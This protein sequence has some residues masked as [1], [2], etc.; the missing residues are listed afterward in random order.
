DDPFLR[1]PDKDQ[2]PVVQPKLLWQQGHEGKKMHVDTP[3]AVVGDKVLVGSAFLDMEKEGDRALYCLDTGSGK[4]LWRTPLKL[5]PWG[6]PTVIGNTVVITGSDISYDLKA[7]DNTNK[8]FVGA[9][10]LANGK[11]LWRKDI[12]KGAITACAAAADGVVVVTGTDGNIRA[13]EIA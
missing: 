5:N 7:I 1:E 8:G 3:V 13:F 12:D 2:L 9:Y 4:T 6:G 10:D 11:E